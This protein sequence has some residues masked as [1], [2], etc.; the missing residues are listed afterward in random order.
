MATDRCS[1][2]D[3]DFQSF[4][5]RSLR[6]DAARQQGNDRGDVTAAEVLANIDAIA[7]AIQAV[8]AGAAITPALLRKTHRLLL[9]PT[10]LKEHGGQTRTQQNWIGG[11]SYNPCAA[12]FVPAPWE[13]VDPLLEDLCA[14][15]MMTRS[16]PSRKPRSRTLNSRQ[17]IP[18]STA[19][20]ALD[21]RSSIWSFGAESSQQPCRRRSH[22]FWPR[23]S[24]TTSPD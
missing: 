24:K 10:M 2:F 15:A 12:S 8:N 5:K 7:Y 13:M 9:E 20:G 21:A 4:Q 17:S 11:S 23:V 16:R 19:T 22:W 3:I 6:A 1:C 14:F 18:L